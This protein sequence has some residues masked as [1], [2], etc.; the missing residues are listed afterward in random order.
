M[1]KHQCAIPSFFTDTYL[2]LT[3]TV[4]VGSILGNMVAGGK[5][6]VS[7]TKGFTQL[8]VKG[9]VSKNADI[10]SAVN[11]KWRTAKAHVS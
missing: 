10:Q 4:N 9:Q 3:K 5:R 1:P 8:F 11:P 6:I 2:S 7:H